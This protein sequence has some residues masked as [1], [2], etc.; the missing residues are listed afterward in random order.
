MREGEKLTILVGKKYRKRWRIRKV[1]K[2]A[3]L[4]G[5]RV[6]LLK[7]GGGVVVRMTQNLKREREN[8]K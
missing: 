4:D 6:E 7:G 1:G 2:Y 5:V 8:R 3:K